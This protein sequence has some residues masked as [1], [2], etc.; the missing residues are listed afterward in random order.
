M[1][2]RQSVQIWLDN[3]VDA[4]RT[5]DEAKIGDLFSEDAL[6]FFSPFDDNDPV[7][8]RAAIVANWLE[9]PDD[10]QLWEARYEPV[11]VEGNVAVANGRTRYLLPDDTLEREFDNIFVLHF[12]NAGRCTR[13][14]EWYMQPR[15][16]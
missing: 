11:A 16:A 7:R 14:T 6:Y 15:G 2:N 5:Y 9:A 13:F 8:G 10:P 12:D 4:W 1:M 3:Y